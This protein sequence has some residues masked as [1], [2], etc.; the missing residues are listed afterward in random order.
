MSVHISIPEPTLEQRA[1][2]TLGPITVTTSWYNVLDHR[3]PLPPM[4]WWESL[5]FLLVFDGLSRQFRDDVL[6]ALTETTR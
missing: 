6:R 2:R 3:E 5:G 4:E 1:T